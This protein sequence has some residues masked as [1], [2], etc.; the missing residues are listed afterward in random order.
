MKEFLKRKINREQ[1]VSTL[2]ELIADSKWVDKFL[3]MIFQSTNY[4]VP[5]TNSDNN[6]NP[7][8]STN[9]SKSHYRNNTNSNGSGEN[10]R[11]SNSNNSKSLKVKASKQL[12]PEEII[13]VS[14][15]N[16]RISRNNYFY[17]Y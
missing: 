2:N 7:V 1:L 4:N 16:N 12:S 9:K 3:G 15:Y 17:F 10:T 14:N 11:K 13:S 8:V 5:I 6:L